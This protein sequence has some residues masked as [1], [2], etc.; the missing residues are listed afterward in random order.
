MLLIQFLSTLTLFVLLFARK[1]CIFLSEF[2]HE[3]AS[4]SDITAGRVDRK[5]SDDL[6][7]EVYKIMKND[8]ISRIAKSDPLIVQAGN[9]VLMRNIGNKAMRRYY[10]SSVMRLLARLLLEL[11]NLQLDEHAKETLCFSDALT[12]SQYTSFQVCG[13]LDIAKKED[14]EE[15]LHA[16]S[17]AIKVSKIP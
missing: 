11:R 2:C 17:S 9:G 12:T 7:R 8:D 10:A 6:V 1:V 16:P 5:A 4:Q 3:V 15:D 13:P 14:N